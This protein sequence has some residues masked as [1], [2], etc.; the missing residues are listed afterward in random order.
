[1]SECARTI[2]DAQRELARL[3]WSTGDMAVT[4]PSGVLWLV[5]AHRGEHR[6]VVKAASQATAW[7]EAARLSLQ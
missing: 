3:G 5:Y 2:D 7:R 4:T 1:M 6:I